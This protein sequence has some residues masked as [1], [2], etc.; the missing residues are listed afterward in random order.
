MKRMC[1]SIRPVLI[2]RGCIMNRFE[3]DQSQ[4][5]QLAAANWA[6]EVA[7][8]VPTDKDTDAKESYCINSH[9]TRKRLSNIFYSNHVF[10]RG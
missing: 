6:A 9:R 2:G 4:A 8:S 1:I 10:K 3:F 7:K 5:D